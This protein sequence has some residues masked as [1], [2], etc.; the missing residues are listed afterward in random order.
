MRSARA[1]NAVTPDTSPAPRRRVGHEFRKRPSSKKLLP[2]ARHRLCFCANAHNNPEKD[3][4]EPVPATELPG[5]PSPPRTSPLQPANR[6]PDLGGISVGFQ[7][8]GLALL[9][10]ETALACPTGDSSAT[11]LYSLVGRVRL[12]GDVYAFPRA[13][14]SS[15]YIKKS[16]FVF[17]MQ[18]FPPSALPW[19]NVC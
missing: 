13:L 4:T 3:P 14:S 15:L 1:P 2:C 11:A 7:A 5:T 10:S 6:A 12:I 9:A 18:N 19:Q 17:S 16:Y 8:A